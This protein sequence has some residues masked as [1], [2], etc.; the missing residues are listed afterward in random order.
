MHHSNNVRIIVNQSNEP[1]ARLKI[2]RPYIFTSG[3]GDILANVSIHKC[4]YRSD[5]CQWNRIEP[6]LFSQNDGTR[7][8][9]RVRI[10]S[11]TVPF[12]RLILFVFSRQKRNVRIVGYLRWGK[13]YEVDHINSNWRDNTIE[14]LELVTKKENLRRLRAR[15]P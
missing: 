2:V 1:L 6:F 9:L 7:Y 13:N 3:L 8:D 15:T 11:H 12:H 10:G 4:D 14:N 5:P